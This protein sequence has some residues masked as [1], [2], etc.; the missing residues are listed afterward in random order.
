MKN[1]FAEMLKHPIASM[2]IIG[3]LGT[4]VAGIIAAAT[5]VSSVK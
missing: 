4:A 5:G 2:L 3:S 1:I